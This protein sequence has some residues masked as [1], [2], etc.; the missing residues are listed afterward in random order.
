MVEDL[1]EEKIWGTELYYKYK[2]K[3]I[4][5]QTKLKR[6]MIYF[7][8]FCQGEACVSCTTATTVFVIHLYYNNPSNVVFPMKYHE[9][10]L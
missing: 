5:Q 9:Q 2:Y 10:F 6:I 3:L 1:E 8:T 7:K 4:V